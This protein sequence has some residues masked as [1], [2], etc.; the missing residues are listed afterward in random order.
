MSTPDP[1][2]LVRVYRAADVPDAQL[3]RN[4]LEDAE[5][6]AVVQGETL[7][8]AM[9]DIP[10]GPSTAPTVWV[11][12]RNATRARELVEQRE[13]H[14]PTDQPAWTCLECGEQIEGQF[15]ECWQCTPATSP[16]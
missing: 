15:A 7:A 10:V 9:G 12:A 11:H 13:A 16:E 2:E 1:D 4:M 8:L 6:S 5:I 14:T 3:V